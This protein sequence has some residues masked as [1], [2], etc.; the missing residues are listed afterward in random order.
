MIIARG[1]IAVPA[2]YF[3]SKHDVDIN[4]VKKLA[5]RREVSVVNAVS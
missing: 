3:I 2:T 4:I 1:I 5:I